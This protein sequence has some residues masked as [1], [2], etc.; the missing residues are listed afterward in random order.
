MKSFKDNEGREWVVS[1]NV[2]TLKR[3]R[4]L[5]DLDLAQLDPKLLQRLHNASLLLVDVVYVACRP[6]AEKRGVTDEQFG[7]AMAGTA[8]GMARQ[9]LLAELLDFFRGN[10]QHEVE[11]LQALLEKANKLAAQHQPADESTSGNSSTAAPASAESTPGLSLS[12][13]STG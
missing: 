13:N 11:I 5:L 2:A 6:E 4:D 7:A 3:I 12:A 1:V 9:A 10:Q 8:I